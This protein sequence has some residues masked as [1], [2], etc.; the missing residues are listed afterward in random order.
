M[1]LT[2][3]FIKEKYNEYNKLYF[4][5]YLPAVTLA[6]MHNNS[7]AGLFSYKTDMSGLP[8][9]NTYKIQIT[10]MIDW[11]EDSFTSVLLHEMIHVHCLMTGTTINF[12]LFEHCG[13]F[14]RM[15]NK[16]K[17]DYNIII[18]NDARNCKWKC[19]KKD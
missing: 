13:E 2:K 11:D 9:P 3:Q 8:R 15:K 5:G 17:K 19:I 7:Y 12:W 10:N 6:I 14:K 1:E 16:F 18:Y 4:N